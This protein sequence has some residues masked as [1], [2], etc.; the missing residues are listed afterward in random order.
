MYAPDLV[1]NNF[2]REG[3]LTRRGKPRHSTLTSIPRC[4]IRTAR[5]KKIVSTWNSHRYTHI[6]TDFP[7]LL[8]V[9]QHFYASGSPCFRRRYRLNQ[10]GVTKGLR[11]ISHGCSL[12]ILRLSSSRIPFLSKV[13]RSFRESCA[14]G[15]TCTKNSRERSSVSCL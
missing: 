12:S 13:G 15:K 1:S 14:A 7:N 5:C 8:V 11:Q 3:T 9:K 10:P 2:Q 6:S 4:T